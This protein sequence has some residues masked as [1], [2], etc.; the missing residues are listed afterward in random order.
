MSNNFKIALIGQAAFGESVLD[1]LV[2]KGETVCGVFCPPAAEGRPDDP[3]KS[4]AERHGIPVFTFKRIRSAEAVEAYKTLGAD[5][6]V[7]AFV[8]DIVS[9]D[10]LTAPR[11]GTIQYHPSLLP[12]HRGPSS[13][14]W[15]I[16]Q[17][18]ARTGL[19]IFWPDEGLDTGPI[20]MQKEVEIESDD[21]LGTIYFDKLFPLGVEAM[22]ESVQLVRE[23]KAPRIEQDHS[24][25]TYEGWCKAD[26][27]R[28]DW[29]L[30]IDTIHNLIRGTD[31]SPGA[32]T[33]FNGATVSLF[34]SQRAEHDG[35]E[36]PGEILALNDAGVLV[37]AKGGA[38]RIGRA[39]GAGKKLSAAEWAAEADAKV[40]DRLGG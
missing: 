3:M 1:A 30:D 34:A 24:Q 12:K 16:I 32:H 26:E 31:P 21:T 35:S 14:N 19:S 18:E 22:V 17:G 36:A 27:A 8:T 10:I 5:L 7:M 28:I 11:L 40:G 38:L 20:L 15:P 13:I 33:T 4:A 9:E 39:R 6:G 2:A 29:S 37:A 25:A 23:N